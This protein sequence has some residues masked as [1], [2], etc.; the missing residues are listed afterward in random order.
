MRGFFL[1]ALGYSRAFR[2]PGRPMNKTASQEQFGKNAAAY[3]TS[4][5]H[6]QGK[7]LQRLVDLTAP[8][9]I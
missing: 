7:S 6:A 4:K 1:G 8:K 5:P 9:S 2:N 3:L